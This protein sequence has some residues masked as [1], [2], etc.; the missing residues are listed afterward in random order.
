VFAGVLGEQ[1]LSAT[2]A[3]DDYYLPSSD[4]GKTAIVFAFPER[5][6]FVLGDLTV[7]AAEPTTQVSWWSDSW[8]SR[9]SLTGGTAPLSFKGFAGAVTSLPAS[10][11]VTVCGTTFTTLPGTSPPPTRGVPSYMGVIVADSVAKSGNA[12]AGTWGKIVVVKTDPG[13]APN[14]GHPGTGTVV[15]TYCD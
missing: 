8:W 5:G 12:I 7:D 9:N 15:A 13:Y 11:P 6:A 4:T 10:T 1:P 14:A 2:F 3:G